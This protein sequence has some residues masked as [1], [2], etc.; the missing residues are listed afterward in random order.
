MHGIVIKCMISC[1]FMYNGINVKRFHSGTFEFHGVTETDAQVIAGLMSAVS[2][3]VAATSKLAQSV[4]G[5]EQG[6][7]FPPL[8]DQ[9]ARP[10]SASALPPSNAERQ[11][12]EYVILPP[13]D[14]ASRLFEQSLANT[15]TARR[16]PLPSRRRALEVERKDVNIVKELIGV[17]I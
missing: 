8:F 14:S 7:S 1:F 13:I 17:V 2:D 11:E 3:A 16:G 6:V 10:A 15:Q 12:E 4:T 5:H 9:S